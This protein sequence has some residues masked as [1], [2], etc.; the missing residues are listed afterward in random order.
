MI[1]TLILSCLLVA[2]V[3]AEQV[4][5]AS[6]YS[7]RTNGGTVTASGRKLNDNHMIAAHRTLRFGTKIKVTN[8]KNGKSVVLEIIDRGPYIKG[9]IIDVSQ[10][11][12]K[13]LGF[14]KQG[15]TKVKV[16]KIK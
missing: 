4:G 3:K 5:I 15:L 10:A 12:A 13:S 9:R 2:S 16:E 6:H 7:V 8:L 1:R 11:A 14:H